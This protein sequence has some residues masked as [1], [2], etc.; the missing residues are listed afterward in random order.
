M[1]FNKTNVKY[2]Q[3]TLDGEVIYD[4]DNFP[5]TR[6]QGSKQ[7]LLPWFH[8]V[9]RRIS[10]EKVLDG[11]SG[12]N[13]VAYYFK[14]QKKNVTANDIMK[15]GYI[16]GKAF[17]ENSNVN[18]NH[19]EVEKLLVLPKYEDHDHTIE[20]LYTNYYYI[21][22]E[23][24]WL[25]AFI[26]N[27]SQMEDEFKQS[28]AYWA[29][30]Q[31]CIIKRPFNLF[32]RKN[33]DMRT[34]EV[35]RSFGNKTTWDK[36]FPSYIRKFVNEANHAIFDN[37]N[38]N[39]SKNLD[40]TQYPSNEFDLV[41]LDPPYTKY[42]KNLSG[43]NYQDYYHFLEGIL[44]Y[45]RWGHNISLK[46]NHKPFL[47]V[48]SDWINPKRLEDLFDNLF[49]KFQ[50]STIVLSYNTE[51]FPSPDKLQE[52]LGSYKEKTKFYYKN[53]KYVLKKQNQSSTEFLLVG[54]D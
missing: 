5:Q 14:S 22:S 52:I 34:R 25:D 21:N 7:K 31:A 49:Q 1:E 51:G 3:L 13:A 50:S 35:K 15:S 27:V 54:E 44:H 40:I 8:S 19:P 4:F 24:V 6:F 33:L 30:F 10:Y 45:D 43:N 36:T 2:S 48:I 20:D 23:N 18:L 16:T 12:S 32:H 9:F 39:I 26:Q 53:I 37:G 41:Y 29:L 17:I 38:T 42:K 11:F 28:I 46:H 47:T